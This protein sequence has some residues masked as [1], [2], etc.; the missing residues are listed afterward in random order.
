MPTLPSKNVDSTL[1]QR[2]SSDQSTL[3]TQS[4]THFSRAP[5]SKEIPD[6]GHVLATVGGTLYLY[7]KVGGKVY[8]TPYTAV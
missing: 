6:Q 2:L 7:T 5:V 8:R 4:H 3:Q 1:K